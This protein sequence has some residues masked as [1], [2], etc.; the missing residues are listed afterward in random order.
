IYL[1]SELASLSDNYITKIRFKHNATGAPLTNSKDWVV[2]M[3]HTPKASFTG[4]TDWI[5]ANTLAQVFNGAIAVVNGQWLEL[6]LSPGFLWDGTSNIVVAVDENTL[7]YD[8]LATW[9][10]FP[11]GAARGLYYRSDSNN[12]DPN[13]PPT[14]SAAAQS[15]IAQVQLVYSAAPDCLPP[16]GLSAS[17]LS[18][19][20]AA[21][22][23][24]ASIS[25]P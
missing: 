6:E 18:P 19:T 8:G 24:T 3:G 4:T 14:A 17:V 25:A 5:P 9:A 12:P 1:A 2:Y 23:W 13:S 15:T 20:S 7:S 10:A 21:F 22:S 16:D 11:A